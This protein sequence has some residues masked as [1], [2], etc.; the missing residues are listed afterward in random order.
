MSVLV[1]SCCTS[2]CA[3][4]DPPASLTSPPLGD[5]GLA[6]GASAVA[7]SANAA[8]C[9]AKDAMTGNRRGTTRTSRRAAVLASASA[10]YVRAR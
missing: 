7:S 1:G 5:D 8:G 4:V 10:M 3:H 9:R 2:A 6:D